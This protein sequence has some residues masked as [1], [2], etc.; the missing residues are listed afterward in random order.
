MVSQISEKVQFFF[1]DYP[2]V[3]YGKGELLIRP[4]DELETIFLLVSGHV[5][6]YDISS[7][8]NEV[9]VNTFKPGAY[10]PMSLAINHNHN[11]YFFETASSVTMRVA[12]AQ[13]VVEF[14]RLHPDVCFDLLSRVYYGTDGL[15]RRMA[16]LMGGKA[17]SRLV[18][19]LLNA[20]ARFGQKNESGG[21]LIPLTEKDIAKRSGLSRET[22]NRAMSV[23]KQDGLVEVRTGSIFIPDTSRLEATIGNQ[24]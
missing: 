19:E 6:E 18:F 5:I 2:V 22:V 16:H 4:G 23:L 12:P 13:D 9:V 1:S 17:K 10:F 8:G 3:H 20:S 7:A 21:S 11:D 15:M 24:L 14:I